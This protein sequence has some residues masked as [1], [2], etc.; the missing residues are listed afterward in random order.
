MSI[1]IS[2]RERLRIKK[3]LAMMEFIDVSMRE[4][5]KIRGPD[6]VV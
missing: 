1:R 6:F 4:K 3:M 2:I 5:D